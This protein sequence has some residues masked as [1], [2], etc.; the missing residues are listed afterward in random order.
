MLSS[1]LLNFRCFSSSMT[2]IISANC[3]PLCQA[4]IRDLGFVGCD[5]L[6]NLMLAAKDE[7]VNLDTKVIYKLLCFQFSAWVRPFKRAVQRFLHYEFFMGC[8]F[9]E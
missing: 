6:E 5:K 7:A 1:E 4:L 8:S 2:Y 9:Q 3:I